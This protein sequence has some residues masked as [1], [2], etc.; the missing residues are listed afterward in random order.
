MTNSLYLEDKTNNVRLVKQKAL[1]TNEMSSFHVCYPQQIDDFCCTLTVI[2]D[3]E[4][5]LISE[6]RGLNI[7]RKT[8]DQPRLASVFIQSIYQQK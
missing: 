6:R 3:V 2:K 5:N 1:P 7:Q 8:T 4:H